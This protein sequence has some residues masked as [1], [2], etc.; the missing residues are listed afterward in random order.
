MRENTA[1]LRR[2]GFL[3][4]SLRKKCI[5]EVNRRFENRRRKNDA[6]ESRRKEEV[7]AKIPQMKQIEREMEANMSAFMDFAFKKDGVG[8]EKKFKKF[9]E[10][11]ML[12]QGQRIEL[13]FEAGYPTDYLDEIF[14]CPDCKDTGAVSEELCKCYKKE[15]ALEYLRL[16]GLERVLRQQTFADFSLSYYSKEGSPSPYKKMEAVKKYCE[17]YVSNFSSGAKNLLFYGNPGCGK[18]FLSAA[19]GK[20][21]IDKGVYV[22]YSP[23]QEVVTAFE[24]ER[25]GKGGEHI[26]TEDYIDCDLLILDDLGTEFQT[27]FSDTTLYNLIN[28]RL[29]RGKPFIISTNLD[30][31]EIEESYHERLV[32]RLVYES[33]VFG[34]PEVDIRLAKEKENRRKKPANKNLNKEINFHTPRKVRSSTWNLK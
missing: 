9:K 25:F 10:K 30:L 6:E 29:N 5:A 24:A 20:A 1:N 4:M 27:T 2:K 23:V 16:S 28:S 7:F 8:D 33:D 11:A 17:A 13:L 31:G 26:P 21:L 3:F 19:I 12:L 15:M 14:T 18:S 32:S 22:L 34:F